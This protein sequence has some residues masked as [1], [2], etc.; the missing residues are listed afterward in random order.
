MTVLRSYAWP[1]NLREL[2]AMLRA[3][4]RRAKGERIELAD[5]PFH[6]KHGP[7]PADRHLPLDALLEQVEQRL[8]ALAMKLTHNHQT[9]AAELL[10]IW[11]PRLQRRLEKFGL[12]PKSTEDASDAGG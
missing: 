5:L 11:R 3:A 8:I 10:E 9:R 12:A 4:C 2:Q 6:L 7:V 1:N